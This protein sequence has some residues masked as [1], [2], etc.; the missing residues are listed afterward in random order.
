S[1]Y[2]NLRL[3]EGL[4]ISNLIVV[5]DVLP[6]ESGLLLGLAW[7]LLHG[8]VTRRLLVLVPMGAVCLYQANWPL[9]AKMPAVGEKWQDGVC[10]QTSQA[11]CGPAA[12]A[13][14]LQVNNIAATEAEMAELCLTTSKGTSMLGLY[15]GLKIKTRQTPLDVRP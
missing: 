5:G 13:T 11:T 2:D 12:A 4:P 15:R 3:A 6:M 7:P 9:L 1:W 8:S 14:L 10:R